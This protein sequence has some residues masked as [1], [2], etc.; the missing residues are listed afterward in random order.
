MRYWVIAPYDS[1]QRETFEC[2]WS[3]D[4]AHSTI[5]VGWTE[6]GDASQ[7]SPVELRQKYI[8]TYPRQ[9]KA[10]VTRDCRTIWSFHHELAIGDR[11][12]ARKGTR[13]IVGV[14]E[15]MGAPFY[16]DSRGRERVGGP[17][18]HFYSNFIPV[19]WEAREFDLGRPMLQ[20]YTMVE[21]TE[22]DFAALSQGNPPRGSAGISA[23][24]PSSLSAVDLSP[25]LYSGQSAACLDRR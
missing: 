1:D 20:R 14:G 11:V 25:C 24:A 16:D 6:L 8:S 2:A 5:A 13:R 21:I 15:V 3:Y 22:H 4:L 7:L 9:T 23:V 12:I 10:Y 18:I 17:G 19:R